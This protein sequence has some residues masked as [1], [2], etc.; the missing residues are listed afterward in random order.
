MQ[1][2][3]SNVLVLDGGHNIIKGK[4]ASAEQTFPHAL[5]SLKANEYEEIADRA[6]RALSDDYLVI[7]GRPYV[8]GDEA[9]HYDVINRR[10]GPERYTPDYYGVFVAAMLFRMYK[11]ACSVA[12]FASHPTGDARY[13]EDLARAAWGEW[14]VE[15]GDETRCYSVDYVNTY[16]E[17]LGGV[18]NVI[19]AESGIRYAR[20]EVNQGR[21]L[22]IDI[23][24]GTTDLQSI[25][26]GQVSFDTSVSI[27]IGIQ[28][29]EADF[30]D[31]L[32]A[33]NAARFKNIR[34]IDR[35][36]LRDAVKTGTYTGGGRPIPCGLEIK[37]A[38]NKL[39]NQLKDAYTTKA[40][41]PANW[42]HIVLTGGGS[43]M[44]YQ[45]LLPVLDHGS[46]ILAEKNPAEMHLAN[47]RG[48]LKM[49]KMW[50]MWKSQGWL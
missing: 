33:N 30:E 34:H 10:T 41:G 15:H 44:L 5:Y 24:G 46:I 7:N 42:H 23:G 45:H 47:V 12:L 19:L 11:T 17:A 20:A 21:V 29:V 16:E 38:I 6:G 2:V 25:T 27:D 39:M 48:G 26:D 8:I 43:S 1:S 40:K 50:K 3:P 22:V 32:R 28:K 37:A 36:M 31:A 35:S 18:Y 14:K 13:R 49:W 4:T 9:E